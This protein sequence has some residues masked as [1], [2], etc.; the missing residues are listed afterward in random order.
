MSHIAEASGKIRR[1]VAEA[2]FDGE[3]YARKDGTG[4]KCQAAVAMP[5]AIKSKPHPAG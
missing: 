3:Q 5:S 2:P 4:L 1:M